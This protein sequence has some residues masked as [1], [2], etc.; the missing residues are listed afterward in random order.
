MNT[1]KLVRAAAR[2]KIIITQRGEPVASLQKATAADHVGTPFPRRDRRRMPKVKYDS[3]I[4]I[5]E[6][7]DGR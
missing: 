5:S 6:D 3:T 1:G 7:G 2:E 4:Y